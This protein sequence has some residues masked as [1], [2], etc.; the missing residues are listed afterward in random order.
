VLHRVP[1]LEGATGIAE[2]ADEWH[3]ARSGA[4]EYAYEHGEDPDW[5]TNWRFA[6][7]PPA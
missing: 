5:I 2:I 4:R 1:G 3:A 7:P 6:A